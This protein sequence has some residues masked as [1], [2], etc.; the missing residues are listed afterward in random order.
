LRASCANVFNEIGSSQEGA[1]HHV[2]ELLA[3]S[4]VSCRRG[5]ITLFSDIDVSLAAGQLLR[6]EGANGAGKTSLLR[7][8]CGLLSPIQGEVRWRGEKVTRLR[9]SFYS[10]LLYLGHAAALKDDLTVL[11]NLEIATTLAGERASATAMHEALAKAGLLS[12]AGALARTLSQ[13]QKRRAALARLALSRHHLLWVLDEPFNA[14]D[15]AAVSWLAGVI[16]AHL[17]AGGMVVLTSHQGVAFS[18]QI[19]ASTVML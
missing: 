2:S 14:L 10:E 6:V 1:R 16:E 15:R 19:S 5:R 18:E 9:D 12:R 4:K 13:G 7:I 3:L 8:I 11:E 17:G